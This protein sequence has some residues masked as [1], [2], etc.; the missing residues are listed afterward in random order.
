[1]TLEL[2]KTIID[3]VLLVL[4]VTTAVY[5]VITRQLLVSVMLLSLYSL[6][7]ALIYLVLGAPDVAMTEAAV[8]AGI[9]TILML[10]ALLLTGEK[11]K[12]WRQVPTALAVV[13]LTGGLLIY[14]VFDM[15]PYGEK[16]NVTNQHVVPHYITQ[17]QSE[18]GIPNLVTAALAS[19][20]GYDTLGE[21]VVVLTAAL[22]VLL[23]IGLPSSTKNK[24]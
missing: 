14:A 17:T 4:L 12:S 3:I 11:E 21:T 18:I 24:K 16:N 5:T 13:V 10:A 1:M 20:R 9:S 2:I 22:S 7:M 19:Y 8:G 23:V 15:P 6:L